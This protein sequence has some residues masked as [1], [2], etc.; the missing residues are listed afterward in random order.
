MTKPPIALEA[1]SVAAEKGTTYPAPYD[2]PCAERLNRGLSDAFGLEDY[3]VNLVTLP[4]GVWSSQRH[5]HSLEDEF[6]Y[7]LEGRPTLI[8]DE[9]ETPLAPGMCAGFKGG[10]GNGHH[11]VNNGDA[12][13]VF[14]VVGSRKLDDDVDYP[15][16][17]LQLLK[18]R[19]GNGFTRR[20]GDPV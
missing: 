16:Q 7:V 13:A 18:K 2:G 15:D 3:G 8:T 19:R 6:L 14:L 9:G 20:N 10:S 17:D 1:A 4:P 11:L 5:W 12:P